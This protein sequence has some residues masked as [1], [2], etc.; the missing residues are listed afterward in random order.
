MSTTTN[1][2]ATTY[3]PCA[4]YRR[5]RNGCRFFAHASHNSWFRAW[6]TLFPTH[7]KGTSPY[8]RNTN[9][10]RR[11]PHASRKGSAPICRPYLPFAAANSGKWPRR[12]IYG[13]GAQLRRP[14][15]TAGECRY[16]A[17]NKGGLTGASNSGTTAPFS[18]STTTPYTGRG[19]TTS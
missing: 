17:P 9:Y 11:R 18:A 7:A 3:L 12:R 19:F 2:F 14:K 8:C 15:A 13:C 16:C 6:R 4:Y 10:T 1:A 5:N